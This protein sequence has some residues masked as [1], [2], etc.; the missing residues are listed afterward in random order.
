[1]ARIRNQWRIDG[2]KTCTTLEA[3]DAIMRHVKRHSLL[4][5]DR[6]IAL[7]DHMRTLLQLPSQRNVSFSTSYPSTSTIRYSSPLR[8]PNQTS[9][10]R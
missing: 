5:D 1:M 6:T 9:L 2:E 4:C 10:I 7:D 3:V 8:L